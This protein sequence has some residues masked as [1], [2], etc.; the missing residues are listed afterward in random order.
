MARQGIECADLPTA[1]ALAAKINSAC[2]YPIKG[3]LSDWVS[4]SKSKVAPT[5]TTGCC[6]IEFRVDTK[7]YLV[8]TADDPETQAQIRALGLPMPDTKLDVGDAA[9][10]VTIDEARWIPSAP[11]QAI[12][13]AVPD[14]P[15]DAKLG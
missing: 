1:Q 7:T 5:D 15:A 12:A 14:Q 13:V 2:G 10:V 11:G 4:G 9:K 3:K 8:I 6:R